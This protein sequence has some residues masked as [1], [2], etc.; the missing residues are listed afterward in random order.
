MTKSEWAPVFWITGL[1]GSGKSTFAN[2]LL[3]EIRKS[4]EAIGIDGDT[5][6]EVINDPHYTYSTQSRLMGAYRYSRFAKLI[7]DQNVPAV[8][9]TISLFHEIHQWNRDNIKNYIEI[10]IE[11]KL[12]TLIKRDPKGLYKSE[13][14]ENMPGF[15]QDFEAPLKPNYHLLEPTVNDLKTLAQSIVSKYLSH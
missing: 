4:K 6:R 5:M 11:C 2:I 15:G 3:E 1:S 13:N 8:V 10:Y 12:E 7:S 9:S 14:R